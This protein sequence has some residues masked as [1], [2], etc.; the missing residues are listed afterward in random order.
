MWRPPRA[1]FSI[2]G[3]RAVVVAAV[4]VEAVGVVALL[5]G[6]DDAVTAVGRR[7]DPI[8]ALEPRV[9]VEAGLALAAERRASAGLGPRDFDAD[10]RLTLEPRIA[11]APTRALAIERA[12]RTLAARLARRRRL[13]ALV[14]GLDDL[15]AAR[16]CGGRDERHAEPDDAHGERGHYREAT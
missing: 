3:Q 9:T 1:S 16:D 7:A 4:A 15:E 12:D 2:S 11:A 13:G 14:R 6:I 8:L 5:V 10:S